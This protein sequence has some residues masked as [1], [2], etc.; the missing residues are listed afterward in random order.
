MDAGKA[1]THIHIK[2]VY[3]LEIIAEL[4]GDTAVVGQYHTAV[5]FILIKHFG[6]S[7]H[8]IGKAAC[9]YKRN[10]LGSNKQYIFHKLLLH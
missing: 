6:Q 7:S 1:L 5:I 10:T 8:N 2:M 9:L 3:V 4:V